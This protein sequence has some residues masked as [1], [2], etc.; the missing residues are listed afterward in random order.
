MSEFTS[1]YIT[2]TEHLEIVRE[3]NPKH[4]L[5]LNEQWLVFFMDNEED[6]IRLSNEVPILGFYNAEDHGWGYTINH[7]EQVL[8]QLDISYELEHVALCNLIEDKYPDEDPVELLYINP[9]EHAEDIN[10]LIGAYL[11]SE[12]YKDMVRKQFDKCNHE[13]FSVFHV[14]DK[15]IAELNAKV[16]YAY[17]QSAESIHELVDYFKAILNL[18]EMSWIR[19]DRVDND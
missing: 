11:T 13:S 4:I 8:S 9:G 1:G 17:S 16:S 6:M 3:G 12:E 5:P 10:E 7:Q 14:N 15:D 18:N 19:P 2:L